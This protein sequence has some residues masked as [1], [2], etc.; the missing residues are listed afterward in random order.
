[1]NLQAFV[2]CAPVMSR[3]R[4][5]RTLWRDYLRRVTFVSQVA[6]IAPMWITRLGGHLDLGAANPRCS[7]GAT[8]SANS[9]F[10][11]SIAPS[12]NAFAQPVAYRDILAAGGERCDDIRADKSRAS[13][14]HIHS[15][16]LPFDYFCLVID[17]DP[18]CMLSP[19]DAPA[20]NRGDHPSDFGTSTFTASI[21]FPWTD[22]S[23]ASWRPQWIKPPSLAGNLVRTRIRTHLH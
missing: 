11:A 15:C 19:S 3:S 12:F 22:T 8:T 2:S 16:T 21:G 10:E 18:N 20:Y 6:V 5:A 7:S 4:V 1:M 17:R 13:P 14:D 9:C 23:L